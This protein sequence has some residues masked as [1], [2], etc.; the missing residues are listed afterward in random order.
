MTP[1]PVPECA[2]VRPLR[3]DAERNRQRILRAAAEIFTEQGLQA[4]LDDVARRAGVGVATV[5]R[6]FPD[7]EALADALFTERLDALVTLAEDALADP[8]EWGSLVSFLEQ[9]G[10]L[11]AADRGLRQLFMFA[12]YG[13]DR[14]GQARARMQPLVTKLVSRAQAAGVVRADLRPTDVPLIEFMLAGVAEYARDTRP[15]V[16]RRYL[17][18]VLDGLRPARA[19]TTTLPEP[20][21]TPA[22][23]EVAMRT[24]PPRRPG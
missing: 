15:D 9:A 14:V 11:L 12:T 24:P 2:P 21:L 18:L 20:A 7:K 3:R 1:T 8:D 17:A 5:Y 19:G 4:T 22:E 13:H 16:W 6:R 23:I 10:A